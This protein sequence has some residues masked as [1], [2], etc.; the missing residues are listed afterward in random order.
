MIGDEGK[1]RCPECGLILYKDVPECPRCFAPIKPMP[2][3]TPT[4]EK[5][6]MP[7]TTEKPPK[8]G[9]DIKRIATI[10]LI[11][12]VVAIVVVALSYNFLIPRIE[13]K[14]I[15]AYRESSGLAINVDSKVKN[16]GTLGINDFLMNITILNS[17]EGVVAK[18]NYNLSDLDAHS[19]HNFDNIY[20]FGD[21]YEKYRILINIHFESSGKDYSKNFDHTVK[22][23]MLVRFEDSYVKWGG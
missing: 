10:L 1:A 15:T 7:E 5:V 20:F 18:G 9:K 4:V 16:E 22:D 11:I 3:T 17:S 12:I 6:Y 8:E 13:L 2:P 21:Q 14:I 19:S 23:Y